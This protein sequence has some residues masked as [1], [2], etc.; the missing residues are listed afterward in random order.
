M[1]HRASKNI[2]NDDGKRYWEVRALTTDTTLDYLRYVLMYGTYYLPITLD[3]GSPPWLR[4]S[5]AS[6][7][8]EKLIFR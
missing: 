6:L 8:M 3:F 5:D 2:S 4:K 7:S 1:F